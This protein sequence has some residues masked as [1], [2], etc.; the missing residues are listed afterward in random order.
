MEQ[1]KGAC[2]IGQSGGPTAVINA[3]LYGAISAAFA[4]PEI[5]RVLGAHHGIAGILADDLYDLNAED[6]AELDL[7]PF[8]PSSAL[9]S[10][11]Y[12]LKDPDKETAEFEKLLSIFKKYDVRYFFYIGGNDSMDTCEKVSRYMAKSGYPIR[13]MG[14]PKTIDNDL[15]G[16]DHCPGYGSAAKFI[17]TSMME[18]YKDCRVYDK[19]TIT[20]VEV[21]GRNAGWLTAAASLASKFGEGPDLVYLPE[22]AFVMSEFIDRALEIYERQGGVLIAASEGIRTADGKLVIEAEGENGDN[23]VDSFGHVQLGG[24]AALLSS[25]LSQRT[26]AKVRAIELSLLQRCA[27]HCA[28]KT[29][30]DE[31]IM[32]GSAAVKAAV[33]G[34]SGKMAAFEVSRSGGYSCSVKFVP[35][36]TSANAENCVPDAWITDG[37]LTDEFA[38]YVMPL[39]QG[40]PERPLRHSLPRFTTLKRVK[41]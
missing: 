17:A 6:R 7:L 20:V 40:E 32:A 31:A 39:I 16:T 1:L 27:S 35:L 8:T 29:D 24:V 19:R 30:I 2:I 4:A 23:F 10:C 12:K 33:A 13:V 18:V 11:R 26:D 9:G 21:M 28:S 14:I 36:T 37:G 34:D 22:R 38:D 15:A 3:S 5:T 25:R 41:A